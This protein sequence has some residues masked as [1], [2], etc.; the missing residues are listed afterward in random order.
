MPSGNVQLLVLPGGFIIWQSAAFSQVFFSELNYNS[1]KLN[2]KK[3]VLGLS[4]SE[5]LGAAGRAR[6][7]CCGLAVFHGNSFCVLHLP[8]APAL[9]TVTCCHE[10][11]GSDVILAGCCRNNLTIRFAP[12]QDFDVFFPRAELNHAGFTF[13]KSSL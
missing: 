7:L 1:K 5:H 11:L 3:G 8:L 13:N 2:K 6:S 4:Y 9:Y 10:Q 12:I